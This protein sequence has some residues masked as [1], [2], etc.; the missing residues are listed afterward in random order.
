V[1]GGCWCAVCITC[2]VHRRYLE[3]S[4][5]RVGFHPGSGAPEEVH[6]AKSNLRCKKTTRNICDF[7]TE[8]FPHCKYLGALHPYNELDRIKTG[9]SEIQVFPMI[10]QLNDNLIHK[11]DRT[12]SLMRRAVGLI[13]LINQLGAFASVCNFAQMSLSLSFRTAPVGKMPTA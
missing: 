1:R 12:F 5:P 9:N 3:R 10:R 6:A 4:V 13:G 2:R 11:D 8:V 7:E